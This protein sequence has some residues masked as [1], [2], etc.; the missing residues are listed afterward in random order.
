MAMKARVK[1]NSLYYGV[2]LRTQK[3]QFV[4][5]AMPNMVGR[6][7]AAV[8]CT[9]TMNG[10]RLPTFSEVETIL[11]SIARVN[12]LMDQNGGHKI[13]LESV[14]WLDGDYGHSRCLKTNEGLCYMLQ[15]RQDTLSWWWARR[16]FRLVMPL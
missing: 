6:L 12:A 14:V 7:D 5:S 16:E 9:E 4:I 3:R 11:D 15:N 13:D 1:W 8:L 10:W 2:E